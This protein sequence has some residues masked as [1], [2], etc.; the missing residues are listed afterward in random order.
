MHALINSLK[1]N[2]QY[3]KLY[4]KMITRAA[5]LQVNYITQDPRLLRN[6]KEP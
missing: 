5:N 3:E 2:H 1:N 4:R 6:E